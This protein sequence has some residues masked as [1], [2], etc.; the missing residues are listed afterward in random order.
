[1]ARAESG[2]RD[3]PKWVSRYGVVERITRK[4]PDAHL[5]DGRY[6]RRR[7]YLTRTVEKPGVSP[8]VLMHL[9]GN[10]VFLRLADVARDLPP[11]TEKVVL[12]PLDQQPQLE[13]HSQASA[14]QRLA[15]EL[16]Q[17]VQ[18]AL[19]QG[20]KRL[21]GAYLQSLLGYPDGC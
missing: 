3:E 16:R 1:A 15:S 7:T 13:G 8:A 11:Y 5:H 10:T 21:L 14:Y 12:L 19:R 18:S 20:S 9:I 6:S 4:A 17:A 2:H